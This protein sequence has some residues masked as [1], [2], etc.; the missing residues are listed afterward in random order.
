MT[1]QLLLRRRGLLAVGGSA[2]PATTTVEPFVSPTTDPVPRVKAGGGNT[3]AH[4]NSSGSFNRRRCYQWDGPGSAMTDVEVLGRITNAAGPFSQGLIGRASSG[5]NGYVANINTNGDYRLTKYVSGV[6]TELATLA[7]PQ[8][9][10]RWRWVRLRCEGTAIKAKFWLDGDDEPAAWTFEE[11]DADLAGPGGVGLFGFNSLALSLPSD[12]EV[13][14]LLYCSHIA[15]DDAGGTAPGPDDTPGAGQTVED[16]SGYTP[17]TVDTP[18]GWTSIW[19]TSNQASRVVDDSMTPFL[20]PV[21]WVPLSETAGA[22]YWDNS[23]DYVRWNTGSSVAGLAWRGLGDLADVEVYGEVQSTSFSGDNHVGMALGLDDDLNGY[24]AILDGNSSFAIKRM[25]AGALTQLTGAALSHSTSTW[26][27]I[28]LRR[29]GSTLKAK[30]WATADAEPTTG[31]PD[32]DGYQ[33]K[34]TDTTHGAGWAGVLGDE[35]FGNKLLRQVE[36]TA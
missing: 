6:F 1:R 23:N 14:P 9:A 5:E 4:W 20:P 11:T 28:R 21:G 2:P 7:Q 24:V 34:T 35:F 16:F 8:I 27:S 18:A 17:S 13:G 22:D 19:N 30:R 10:G 32:G 26:Y 25:T 12:P 29:E 36:V 15:T 3:F 33:L 31:G